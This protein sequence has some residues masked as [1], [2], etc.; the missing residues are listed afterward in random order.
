MQLA[1]PIIETFNMTIVNVMEDRDWDPF[2]LEL[3]SGI[4]I[5]LVSRQR[6]RKQPRAMERLCNR[7]RDY[8]R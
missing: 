3:V 2:L 5:I 8:C 6:S 7:S 4:R 1:G